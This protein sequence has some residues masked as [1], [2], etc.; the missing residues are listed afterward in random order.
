MLKRNSY[1]FPGLA[2]LGDTFYFAFCCFPFAF[3]L[4]TYGAP[5]SLSF[6]GP[7]CGDIFKWNTRQPFQRVS[8][9]VIQAVK[10]VLKP[11]R[12][13]YIPNVHFYLHII[14]EPSQSN[15]ISY[16]LF[17]LFMSI[18]MCPFPHA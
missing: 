5:S 14:P 12:K 7:L 1:A 9:T 13:F 6:L 15:L 17:I 10:R 2:V 8:H 4:P 16:D 11:T 18:S 3:R